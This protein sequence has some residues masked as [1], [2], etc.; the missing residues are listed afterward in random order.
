MD[1]DLSRIRA[2]LLDIDGVLYV[3]NHALP[4]AVELIGR[5]RK[6]GV[7]FLLLSNNTFRPVVEQVRKLSA[8]GIEVRNE[9]VLTAAQTT[10]RIMAS[11]AGR[12]ARCF[13]IGEEGLV[14]ALAEAGL[15]VLEADA[16]D[17]DYVVIGMDRQL[18]YAKLR[19]AA[20]AIQRGARFISS[21]PDPAYP[22]EE[23]LVPACGAI[24][25]A[26][27]ATTGVAARVTG[28]PNVAGFQMSLE[29]LGS[30]PSETAILGDQVDVDIL[31]GHRAGIKT[32][33]ILSSIT[34]RFD[35]ATAPVV[36]DALFESTAAFVNAWKTNR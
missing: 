7:P 34:P 4:G 5:L 22:T 32:V 3:G 30:N 25:A 6:E 27:E 11:E 33:L 29:M 12:R 26:L 10:A 28:K 36:P 23:G 18:T 21:N 8:L 24:Q 13:V 1:L 16:P 19:T 9:E 15:E 31:G 35:P 14:E 2:L 20:L 17:I